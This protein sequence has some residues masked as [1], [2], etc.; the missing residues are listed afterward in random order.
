MD[1][2]QA[3]PYEENSDKNKSEI[4]ELFNSKYAKKTL[5]LCFSWV[6]A[7]FI[8]YAVMLMLPSILA[9]HQ[10]LTPDFQYLFLIVISAV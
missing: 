2:D 4:R 1:S 8:Y 10:K 3:A 5:I 7:C 9:R 6:S